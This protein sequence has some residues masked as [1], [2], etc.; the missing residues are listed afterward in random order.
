[1][2]SFIFRP[3]KVVAECPV[4]GLRFTHGHKPGDPPNMFFNVHDEVAPKVPEQNGKPYL[5]KPHG[6]YKQSCALCLPSDHPAKKPKSYS[7][8]LRG[9]LFLRWEREIGKRGMPF[10]GNEGFYAREMRRI[11][12]IEQNKL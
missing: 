11:I 2:E 1:M 10:E 8:L 7:Q 4:C 12:S 5:C 3:N 6:V 9:V